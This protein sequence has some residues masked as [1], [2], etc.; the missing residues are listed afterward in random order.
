MRGSWVS[1]RVSMKDAIV[2]LLQRTDR[3]GSDHCVCPSCREYRTML[4]GLLTIRNVRLT[5]PDY[6][7][8][9]FAEIVGGNRKQWF[10]ATEYRETVWDDVCLGADEALV[11]AVMSQ[12]L[13]TIGAMLYPYVKIKA[14]EMERRNERRSGT[15]KARAIRWDIGDEKMSEV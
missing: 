5:C 7:Y 9:V 15:G 10:R 2:E 4:R 11:A 8:T 6:V 13:I 12:K 3:G 1:D 14:P